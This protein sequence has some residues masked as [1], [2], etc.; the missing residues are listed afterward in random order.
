MY[1][2]YMS[3]DDPRYIPPVL[4]P[5]AIARHR[6]YRGRVYSMT[7]LPTPTVRPSAAEAEALE[8]FEAALRT[9]EGAARLENVGRVFRGTK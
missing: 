4:D 1:T 3:I 6:G 8:I 7:P 5:M 2:V 9:D